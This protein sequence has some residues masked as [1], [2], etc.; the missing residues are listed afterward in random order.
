MRILFMGTPDFAVP[1]LEALLRDGHDLAGVVTQPD[2]PVGRKKILTPPPVKTCALAH[3]LTVY[4]PETL[5]NESFLE[6][7]RELN[8]ELIV[9]VAYGKIL[10]GYILDFPKYGCINV[11][12]SILPRWR[13]AA[14]IQW[15][16][17]AGDRE[18][19]VTTMQMDRGLDTGDML[20]VRKT[21]IGDRETAGELFD[22]LSGMGAELLLETIAQLNAG[23]LSPVPQDDA[24]SCYA[25][26]LDKQMAM[27]NWSRS[28]REI[29]C[30]V[31]GLNPWPVALTK[32]DGAP[33]K[34]YS[35]E[36]VDGHGKP[37]EVL[38]ADT[39]NGLIVACGDGAIR[40]CELQ[41]VGGKRMD[42]RDYLRGHAIPV[43][44]LFAS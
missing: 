15:S 7:L 22:R 10:P 12:G 16:V 6:I 8:P 41:M 36:P 34:I 18:A 39:K 3:G 21:L 29:D 42:A 26:M 24:Q 33:V 32:L 13:G 30:L 27:I 25:S 31:R 1:C 9:V 40:I 37:G 35:A 44:S 5:K 23:T 14:P 17:I 38:S 28:A 2:K 19:G 43:A 20:L 11:H 4:Q